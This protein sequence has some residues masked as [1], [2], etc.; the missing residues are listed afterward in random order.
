TKELK[1]RALHNVAHGMDP[2]AAA[3]IFGCGTRSLRRWKAN[4]A[5]FGDV[6]RPPSLWRGRPRLLTSDQRL[7][8]LLYARDEVDLSLR[9]LQTWCVSEFGRCP[10]LPTICRY[11][12]RAGLT[13]KKITRIATAKDD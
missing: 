9:E 12:A 1:R 13:R 11:L 5:K 10:S 8:L 4:S 2:Q 3:D 6:D 7:A